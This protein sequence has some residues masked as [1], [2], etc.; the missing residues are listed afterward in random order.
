MPTTTSYRTAEE[1]PHGDRSQLGAHLTVCSDLGFSK[2]SN[3]RHNRKTEMTYVITM[4]LGFLLTLLL[5][6]IPSLAP[7]MF[8]SIAV[9]VWAFIAWTQSPKE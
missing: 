6:S 5:M 3:I 8:L 9:T 4:I 1:S 2:K 7:F